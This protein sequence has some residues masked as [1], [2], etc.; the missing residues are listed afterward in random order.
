MSGSAASAAARSR[1]TA[2]LVATASTAAAA[3]LAGSEP[4]MP[5]TCR[6]SASRRQAAHDRRVP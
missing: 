1:S 2:G 4:S 6:I 3:S 5:M